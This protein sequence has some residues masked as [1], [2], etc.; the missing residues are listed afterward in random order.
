[1]KGYLFPKLKPVYFM[2]DNSGVLFF[3][4]NNTNPPLKSVSNIFPTPL[5]VFFFFQV[6]LGRPSQL[7]SLSSLSHLFVCLYLS[8][9]NS[10]LQWFLPAKSFLAL[11]LPPDLSPV[12]FATF[13]F[14]SHLCQY[15]PLL[16]WSSCFLLL[17][18]L[19]FISFSPR[20]VFRNT[21]SGPNWRG[22]ITK[23]KYFLSPSSLSLYL[24]QS[25]EEIKC[26]FFSFFFSFWRGGEAGGVDE[27]SLEILLVSK[28]LLLSVFTW[29][30]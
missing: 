14:L 7:F 12:F 24:P 17:L 2:L 18:Y 8:V 26:S 4:P 28:S 5:A 16:L 27:A 1:M 20:H 15:L 25:T 21:G 9:P 3:L 30:F 11:F 29:T 13:M 10:L 23:G 6:S 19:M 22:M